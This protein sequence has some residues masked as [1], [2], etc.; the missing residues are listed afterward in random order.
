MIKQ[1]LSLFCGPAEKS[2]AFVFLKKSFLIIVLLAA[3]NS[4]GQVSSY[5][6]TTSVVTPGYTT[7]GGTDL[8]TNNWDD[9]V[10]GAIT[11]GFPFNFNG[12]NYTQC[13]VSTNGFITFGSAPSP[14]EYFPL[15]SAATYEGAIAVYGRNLFSNTSAVTY[16]RQGT[17]PN[18]TFT[19]Q[20][21]AVRGTGTSGGTYNMQII[22]NESGVVELKYN[23]V[24]VIAAAV[25]SQYGQIGLRGLNNSD[26]NNKVFGPAASST[27]TIWSD[28]GLPRGTV[29][30][31]NTSDMV[32][33]R[34]N[35]NRSIAKV[36]TFTFT[37]P[38]CFAPKNPLAQPINVSYNG[39]TI[40]WTAPTSAPSGGYD[41]LVTTSAPANMNNTGGFPV[42]TTFP[43]GTVGAGVTS[44]VVATVLN[45]STTYYIYVRSKCAG[46]SGWSVPGIFTTLCP[47]YTPIP[48]PYTQNFN[49]SPLGFVAPSCNYIDVT[50]ATNTGSGQ[51]YIADPS[52][53]NNWGFATRHARIKGNPTGDPAA[54]SGYFPEGL[55]LDST[56]SYRVQ[57]T[58]AASAE[59]SFTA[60][61][62][63]LA[64]GTKPFDAAMTNVLAT[65]ANFRGGPYTNVINFTVP[66]SGVY[67]L[68]FLDTTLAGNATTLL[69]DISVSE[70]TCLT[71][72]SLISGGI[73]AYTATI[74]W[75]SPATPPASGFQY[76]F[77][78]TGILPSNPT[79]IFN[80][81]TGVTSAALS[82]LLANTT[83]YW[84]VRSNCGNGDT[85]GWA[86][87][88]TFHTDTAPVLLTYCTPNYS[89]GAEPIC[90]VIFNAIDN[91]SSCSIGGAKY[92]DYKTIS[93]TVSRGSTY[94]ITV[95]GNTDGSFSTY[96][97][98]F[99]DFDH[100]GT[101]TAAE[102]FQLGFIRNCANCA[103]TGN[104]TIPTGALLG[105][106]TMRVMKRFNQY[107][108]A[109]NT[110]GY[111]EAEDYSINIKNAA[112]ALA[113]TSNLETI[114]AG[115]S[116]TVSI[117]GATLG[118]YNNYSWSPSGVTGTAP[119]FTFTPTSGTVYT[120]TGLNTS[121]FETNTVKFEVKIN[122]APTPVVVTPSTATICQGQS[123]QM[124][125]STGGI[126]NGVLVLKEDFNT[127]AGGWTAANAG[128][129][130]FVDDGNWFLYDDGDNVFNYV[131]HSND[132]TGFAA[133]NSDYQGSGTITNS[134][135]VSP[136]I[137]L[138]G[139]STV[140]L[141][142]WQY[143]LRWNGPESGT[144]EVSRDGGVTYLPGDVLYTISTT[145]GGPRAFV[146][147]TIDL[148]AF[149]GLNNIVIRFRYQ[150]TFDYGWAIDNVLITGSAAS[151][152]VWTPATG[153]YLD[154]GAATPYT[155]GS[156]SKI[157][158]ASPA[159][160]QVYTATVTTPGGS[161]CTATTTA[162]VTVTPII[163]TE[164]TPLD[165]SACSGIATQSIVVGIPG[166]ATVTKWQY[167]TTAS[168]TSPIDIAATTTSLTP[169]QITAAIGVM[170]GDRWFRA[171][172]NGCGVKNSNIVKVTVP[173]TIWNGSVWSNLAPDATKMAVFNGSATISADLNACAVVVQSGIITVSP[174]ITVNIEHGVYITGG[175]MT[176]NNNSS[177]LQIDA[178]AVNTGSVLY[179]RNSQTMYPYDYT[180]W[181]SPVQGQTLALLS[182]AT[183]FDKYMTWDPV[184]YAWSVIAT[185]SSAI[186]TPG[187]GY[188]VRAGTDIPVGGGIHTAPFSGIPN[189]GTIT[190]LPNS[191]YV[192][193]GDPSKNANLLGNPYPSALDA[194]KLMKDP[195]N[196]A[197]LGGG[198]TFYYWTHNTG[199]ANQAYTNSDYATYNYT[200]GTG[201]TTAAAALGGN[202]SVPTK[203]IAAGQAFMASIIGTGYTNVV[204]KN[205]MRVGGTNNQNFYKT[206][207]AESEPE[208]NRLWLEF[209][210]D[211]SFKQLL[212]GYV[213]GAT[214]GYE[215][216]YDCEVMESGNPVSF[217]TVN[218]GKNLTTQGRALPFVNTDVVP[219]GYRA[220]TAG[221]YEIKL[222][223]KDGLFESGEQKVY[224]E[225]RL[226][227]ITHD[228]TSGSY[229]FVT[230][231]GTFNNRFEL[232]YVNNAL[233]TH[234]TAFDENTIV[235]YKDQNGIN[236]KTTGII[237]A[238]V[239][240]YDVK[241]SEL[242][243]RGNINSTA[244][245]ISNLSAAK[246]ML[247]VKIT[248]VDG[249]TVTKK[250][251][252]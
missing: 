164:P 95:Y 122:E 74:G 48:T 80:T 106:T 28:S 25:A 211:Q 187:K 251:I 142:F 37:P 163:T 210:S 98:V 205:T 199:I 203:Y 79:P 13:Y 165:Q 33:T 234:D 154:A 75:T 185:P 109:C 223:L 151:S 22:L 69:D 129:G 224:L 242:L 63:K 150:G 240:I 20:Y 158:Y 119:N 5:V 130:G 218:N 29:N 47:P 214:N 125:T 2:N 40:Q 215:R 146:N 232:K 17:S 53:P 195:D 3:W 229:S 247:L 4:Q 192:N 245:V 114:C 236:L 172:V 12:K 19:I 102:E 21:I 209:S 78:T 43:T 6:P 57:Y 23:A 71:P 166:G 183:R 90:R 144:V 110:A 45:P 44:A 120:L 204:F 121:T 83:Y 82:G 149:A 92:S 34:T 55:Y 246:Q 213:E 18:Q 117:T 88:P 68:G 66:V 77:N 219:V 31:T 228:L 170:T 200:G 193:P 89:D 206:A 72:T 124:L 141:S 238:S 52:T 202:T 86:A 207:D 173:S 103:V 243:F 134:S 178:A 11:I 248:S 104:I 51:W 180:Y 181:S 182:P 133:V 225:D 147:R 237:M 61:N 81:A 26:F 244:A 65:H 113:L 167:A 208:K 73:T 54:E 112:P 9:A 131:I 105:Y 194:E 42:S 46:D 15:S 87:A 252:F 93:T 161:G 186:M 56:K 60:Q 32:V 67:Y 233:A 35:T 8:F 49:S 14:T 168:F 50:G 196:A 155:A 139:F 212:V 85:S 128:S 152:V 126:V 198:T 157:V 30:T 174:G 101:F 127:G 216:G 145:T 39:A 70:S 159:T 221:S 162:T 136:V 250:I 188:I 118:N 153:L 7:I 176:F 197:S 24:T 137:D 115:L 10:S 76:Y 140:S 249:I 16:L 230:E 184:S 171:V 96:I 62:L 27:A 97:N 231:P 132:N 41:Y 1:L 179:R 222:A 135:L 177:L 59:L 84:W 91:S 239:K 226:L 217:Y 160:T 220:T 94:P 169:A 189:N 241:G 227:S 191:V 111:G 64:Y 99:I 116:T 107:S 156:G 38:T 100:S 148:T 138:T 108:T 123:A 143:Y 36:H 235:V 175:S 201:T 190:T 58:Y